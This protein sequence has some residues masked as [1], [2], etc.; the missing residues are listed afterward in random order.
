MTAPPA[1]AHYST[2]APLA[3]R[4]CAGIVA[5]LFF[6]LGAHDIRAQSVES[7]LAPGV[8]VPRPPPKGFLVP[9]M[10]DSLLGK[11]QISDPHF[12]IK[13]GIAML[14]DYTMFSQDAPSVTQVGVQDDQFEVRDARLTIRGTFRLAGDWGYLVQGQYKG[15]DRDATDEDDW[16]ISELSLKRSFGRTA[17][18]FGKLKQTY[19]YE[20]VGDAANL[21]QNERLLSPFFTS[22]DVGIKVSGVFADHATWAIGWFNDWWLKDVTWNESGH[23][24]TGRLTAV[25][26]WADSGQR[27][28]HFGLTTRYNGADENRLR[29]SGKPESNVADIYVDSDNIASD[30][31]WHLG[32]EG[33][34][35]EGPYALLVEY[36]R[37]F[38]SSRDVGDPTFSGWYVT[39]SLVLTG[40]GPRAYDRTVGYAR[41]I[42]VAH[43]FG[44]VELVGRVGHD[45]LDDAGVSGGTL[46]KWFLG[47]NWWATRRWKASI[48]Y[49]N[50]DLDRSALSGNTDILLWRLQ[51][52]Y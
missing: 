25:P 5:L 26:F 41:R 45:D 3:R 44:E 46:N 33:M 13:F 7:D 32:A 37:A 18:T 16:S 10:S 4:F 50:A 47:V 21:P 24:V 15:F 2:A 43:R 8:R 20:M 36:V 9:D 38:V 30:H 51:W 28:L 14:L 48:G 39:G 35:G 12:T 40:G 49:G 1:L 19:S 22:R 34:W 52:I 6:T 11:A 27:Y 17:V 31:A 23:Q 29:L 42:P